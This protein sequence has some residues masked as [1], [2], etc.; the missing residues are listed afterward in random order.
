MSA[1]GEGPPQAAG[2]AESG[3]KD[4]AMALEPAGGA[5]DG[6]DDGQVENHGF[7]I[8]V[9]PELYPGFEGERQQIKDAGWIESTPYNYEAEQDPTRAIRDWAGNAT[10]YEWSG[11]EGDVGPASEELERELF[12]DPDKRSG[13]GIDF[14]T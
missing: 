4:E 1:W 6:G 5:I 8:A 2:P 3:W 13:S 11:E 10:V 9:K 7:D 14:S 12:G